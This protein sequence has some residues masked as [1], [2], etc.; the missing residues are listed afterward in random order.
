MSSTKAPI[1]LLGGSGK[2]AKR[3]AQQLEALKQPVLVASRN[4]SGAN[5]VVFDWNDP[6]TWDNAFTA[7][8]GI[9][10]VFLVAP[11]ILEPLPIMAEYIAF[12]QKQGVRRFVLL[13]A[14]SFEAGG[15]L[16]GKVHAHLKELGE[17]GEIEWAVLRP[18]WFQGACRFWHSCM[19][20][21]TSP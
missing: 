3:I 17:K 9:K 21:L 8:K 1:L 18:T 15:P 7:N 10:A 14:S 13:S 6:N 20:K 11:P 12:A 19:M 2:V 5:G 16:M 4:A